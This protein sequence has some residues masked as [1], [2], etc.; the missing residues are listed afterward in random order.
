MIRHTTNQK[1]KIISY[2]VFHIENGKFYGTWSVETW[3]EATDLEA[4]V[5]SFA[6]ACTMID[7]RKMNMK[8]NPRISR[9]RLLELDRNPDKY[10][11]GDML[12]LQND[13]GDML[14]DLLE[15]HRILQGPNSQKPDKE[16]TP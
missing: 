16:T 14:L 2:E 9:E 6:N 11:T 3:Q 4:R 5:I 1:T 7:M 8:W 15:A 12:E 13:A 10:E